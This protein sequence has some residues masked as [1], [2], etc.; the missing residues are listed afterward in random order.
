MP[1]YW[2]I[3]SQARLI[4]ARAEGEVSLDDALTLLEAVSGAQA[5]SYR[6]LFDSRAGTTSMSP[7]EMLALCFQVRSYHAQGPMGALAVVA[8][9][10]QSWLLARLLGALATA[11]RPMKVFESF[12]QAR[13]WINEQHDVQ[14]HVQD[15][16]AAGV[17]VKA[18]VS[19]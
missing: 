9:P 3:D 17:P 19:R 13:N 18:E 14:P 10:A 4:L 12:R 8:T 11:D 15:N 6:K 2:T 1:V 5:M 7:D 16:K